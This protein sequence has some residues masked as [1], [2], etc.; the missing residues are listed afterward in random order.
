MLHDVFRMHDGRVDEGRFQMGAKVEA[1]EESHK[2][3]DDK[4][5]RKFYNLN[6]DAD[7]PLHENT[8]QNKLGPLYIFIP[9]SVWVDGITQSTYPCLSL[10]VSCFQLRAICLKIHTR[11]KSI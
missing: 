2:Y 11:L 7:K 9:L 5:A 10:S 4:C 1:M 8:K 3:I 6:N